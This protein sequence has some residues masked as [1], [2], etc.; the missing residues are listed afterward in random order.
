MTGRH[1]DPDSVPVDDPDDGANGFDRGPDGFIDQARRWIAR[2]LLWGGRLMLIA[3]PAAIIACRWSKPLWVNA[4]LDAGLSTNWLP[5][6]TMILLLVFSLLAP[7]LVLPVASAALTSTSDGW[8]TAQTV[9]GSR[10]IYLPNA[11]VH[12]VY[13]PGRGWGMRLILL[14]DKKRILAVAGSEL[15]AYNDDAISRLFEEKSRA[16]RVRRWAAG[17]LFLLGNVAIALVLF[18][19]L[20]AAAGI[21]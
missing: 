2:G 7:V 16:T 3:V 8:L 5:T 15:W 12:L 17:W 14:R 19:L 6:T 11:S 13:V 20:P 21:I 4:P 10:K 9:L 1:A 18:T